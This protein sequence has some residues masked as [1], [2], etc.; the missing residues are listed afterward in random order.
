MGLLADAPPLHSLRIW[1]STMPGS[2]RILGAHPLRL[3]MEPLLRREHRVTMSVAVMWL[4]VEWMERVGKGGWIMGWVGLKRP[5][6][7]EREKCLPT[8]AAVYL[9]GVPARKNLKPTQK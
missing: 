7:S 9:R 2:V 1:V 3:D 5:A 8:A 6:V 4:W